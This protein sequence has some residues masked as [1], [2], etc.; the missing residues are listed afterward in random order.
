MSILLLWLGHIC[1]FLYT[2]WYLLTY[3]LVQCLVQT[4]SQVKSYYISFYLTELNKAFR[5]YI[6]HNEL[7]KAESINIAAV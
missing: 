2:F 7:N 3:F 5:M 6:K 4:L 1:M